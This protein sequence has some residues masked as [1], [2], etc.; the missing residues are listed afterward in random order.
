LAAPLFIFISG[1][2]FRVNLDSHKVGL[3][4]NALYLFGSAAFVD[5]F[6]WRITPFYTFDVLYLIAA[7]Q[8]ISYFIFRLNPNWRIIAVA[9]IVTLTI[10][11]QRLL[12]YR[13]EISDI[14][15]SDLAT[16]NSAFNFP[17]V[18]QR[19]F[20]DGWFPILPWLLVFLS[21]ALISYQRVSDLLLE[22]KFVVNL[23]WVLFVASFV[24]FVTVL[25]QEIR[26]GYMEV[27]YPFSGWV[28]VVAGIWLVTALSLSKA[29][30]RSRFILNYVQLLG[31]KSLFVYILHLAVIS[32]IFS[33]LEKISVFYFG[34][35]SIVFVFLIWLIVYLSS[36]EKC[37]LIIAKF[38][39]HFVRKITGI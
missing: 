12:F 36:K 31:K 4:K 23:L 1:M 14:S 21:G 11:A 34:L 38:T 37:K 32:Y 26:N 16:N 15:I 10:I 6:I 19:L 20:F 9:L 2:T 35:V 18:L 8:V 39:P 5:L 3:L 17:S 28:I 25:K 7:S 30:V 13:F 22:K 33:A 27:F 24:F 29:L